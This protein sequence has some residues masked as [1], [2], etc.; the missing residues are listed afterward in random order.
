LR[1]ASQSRGALETSVS[2]KSE[3]KAL[4]LLLTRFLHFARKRLSARRNDSDAER[5]IRAALEATIE[6]A[7]VFKVQIFKVKVSSPRYPG[8]GT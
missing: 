4:P 5:Q 6:D 7:A 2:I 3:R 1:A 8:E